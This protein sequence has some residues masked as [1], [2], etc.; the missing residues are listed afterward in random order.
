MSDL[1]LDIAH[2]RR[3]YRDRS[4]TPSELVEIVHARVAADDPHR[5]WIA[6]LP[7]EQLLAYA[8]ALETREPDGLPLYGIPF[9]IKDNIDLASVPT[10]AGCP[11]FAYT[12]PRSATVVHRLI[13]AGAIPV[14]K[15]NLDQFATGLVGTRSPYGACRNSFDPEY[16]A[17]GS[18]SG[19]AVAVAL[20]QA[21]F[22]LGTDTAGSGRVPAAF[23]NLVGIKP[24][25]GFLSMSGVVPACRTLDCVS[26]FAL[27]VDDA[28][29]VLDAASGFDAADPWSRGSRPGR[30]L[31]PGGFRFGMP[32]PGQLEFFG[33][34]GYAVLF[35]AAVAQ[36]EA[37]GGK[38]VEIDLAPF[39][40][41]ARLLYEGPWL[42]ERYAAIRAF[43]ETKPQALHRVTRA[44]I[45][46]GRE[47]RAV[48]AFEAMYRL[49]SLRRA[50]EPTLHGVDAIVTPTAATIYR[51]AEVEAD[52]VRT[53]SR[54][55]HYT[56]FMNLLDLA[57]VAMPAGFT[58]SG[59]PFGITLF[60]DA[61][62]EPRLLALAA[63]FEQARSLPLGA[64]RASRPPAAPPALPP[65]YTVVAVC[66]AHLSGLPLNHQLTE[67]GAYL[68]ETTR[69]APHYR[70][71]ALS[72]GPPLRPGLVR[73][74][75]DGAPIEIE[76]W[77]L[78]LDH[79]GS[80][81]ADI[82]APLGVAMVELAD[83]RCVQGFVCE[84]YAVA[85]ATDIT[86]HGGW[87]SYIASRMPLG[88]RDTVYRVDATVSPR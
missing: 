9:A 65:G 8:Q 6:R 28:A 56:N 63:R 7:R 60:A 58:A 45:E 5:V 52:P 84:G 21:S 86:A 44:I 24:T 39:L 16:I 13:D 22:A 57:A 14:G 2:L 62:S 64:T 72:G 30:A 85:D 81:V 67:R 19:S 87:R 75:R 74:A 47:G 53:N 4:L 73:V 38:P 3:L 27:T 18:S 88:Q 49:A 12:P 80:F 10:T 79:Y 61:C 31:G 37:I 54:L 23:N 43:I 26:V 20:G 77:A 40:E 68:L 25:R 50:V 42:A 76:V 69:T 82:P 66:G 36:L 15:T 17:G 35:E 78:P 29:T 33:N 46:P 41:A 48:E 11:E 1:S 55:G 70:L 32:R 71:Y 83:G 59:I 51:I 34:T